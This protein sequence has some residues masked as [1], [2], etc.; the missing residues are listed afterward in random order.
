MIKLGESNYNLGGGNILL[1]GV[2]CIQTAGLM[3]DTPVLESRCCFDVHAIRGVC[4]CCFCFAVLLL[5]CFICKMSF[6]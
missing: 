5:G 3:F 1:L 6:F 2:G 4:V